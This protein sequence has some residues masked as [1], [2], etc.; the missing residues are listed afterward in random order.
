VALG[1]ALDFLFIPYFQARTGNG[2]IGVMVSF[3]ASEI[4]VFAGSMVVLRRRHLLHWSAA[5]D[6]ARALGSAGA[7]LLLL[8]ALPPLPAW[9]GI[10]LCV[11]AFSAASLAFG[12]LGLRD[13]AL[14]RALVRRAPAPA[15]S[16]GGRG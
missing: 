3:A 4:V 9:A 10:P 5:G 6:V 12:L 11:A 1:A 14:V 16:A 2:G 15:A 8:G 13:L 7:T